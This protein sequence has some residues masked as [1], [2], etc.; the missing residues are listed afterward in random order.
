M[1]TS[2][3]EKINFPLK[4]LLRPPVMPLQLCLSF[5]LFAAG[6]TGPVEVRQGK[7]VEK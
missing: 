1:Y 7:A 3:C 2:H 4:Y 6:F 5:A